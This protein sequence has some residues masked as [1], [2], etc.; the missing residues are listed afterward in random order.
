MFILKPGQQL[1][2]PKGCLHSFHK[3]GPRT[4]QHL[5]ESFD[6]IDKADPEWSRTFLPLKGLLE[7]VNRVF[8]GALPPIQLFPSCAFDW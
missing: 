7:D 3:A 8:A 2:I 6:G 5:K 4:F 1:H